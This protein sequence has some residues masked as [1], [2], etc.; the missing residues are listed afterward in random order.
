MQNEKE[1]V[2]QIM[3]PPPPQ[4]PPSRHSYV[5]RVRER[6]RPSAEPHAVDRVNFGIREV[7]AAEVG[8]VPPLPL[9]PLS[10]RLELSDATDRP[11]VFHVR[12]AK[13]GGPRAAR[14]RELDEA[15]HRLGDGGAVRDGA[16][17]VLLLAALHTTESSVAGIVHFE[18]TRSRHAAVSK[19]FHTPHPPHAVV[20]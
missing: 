12:R 20:S 4:P 5:Q 13:H 10:Q 16:L 3:P 17:L 14:L 7:E 18:K 6:S 2:T 11:D 19:P 9:L 1:N 8:G 15:R